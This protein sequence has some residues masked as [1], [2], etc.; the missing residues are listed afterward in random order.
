MLES[1]LLPSFN[2]EKIST[3]KRAVAPIAS[4]LRTLF[5]GQCAWK[6]LF[7]AP[8][9]HLTVDALVIGAGVVGLGVARELA[10][11]QKMAV[12]LVDQHG[13]FGCETSSRNSEV[14]HGGI[15]YPV[16]SLKSR[17][18][19]EGKHMLYDYCR[20]KAVPHRQASGYERRPRADRPQPRA[21]LLRRW[22]SSWW[23]R[24]RGSWASSRSC[25]TWR[26]GTASTTSRACRPQTSQPWSRRSN[27]QGPSSPP[28]RRAPP[29]LQP[30]IHGPLSLTSSDTSPQGIVDTHTLMGSLETDCL[31]AGVML[32]Y[33][34]RVVSGTLSAAASSSSRAAARHSIQVED[35]TTGEK[36]T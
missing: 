20:E 22:A 5:P 19:V 11:E 25:G 8:S 4:S 16:G 31:E 13:S 29:P 6:R 14:I 30:A 3:M 26:P 32:A 36:T 1:L 21:A 23:P 34:Q 33:Q 2:C 7:G 17:L 12:L 24:R 15:Y 28:P 27:A 9:E 18:C 10:A 35:T